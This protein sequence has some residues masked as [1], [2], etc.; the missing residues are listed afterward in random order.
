M[1]INKENLFVKILKF[2]WAKFKS[3]YRSYATEY[4]DDIVKKVIHCRDPHF[5]YVEYRCMCCGD[6]YHRSGF[7]CKT[8]FC[9]HCAR[10]SSNDFIEEIMGKL[11]PGVVYRHLILTIPEQLRI[12]FYNN[13]KSG[14]LY[15]RFINAGKA[16]IDDIFRHV[17]GVDYLKT[18][19]VVALHTAG[20]SGTYNPHL[21][22][23]VMAGGIDP[24]TG[25]WIDLPYFK[26]ENLMPKKGQYHLLTMVK[27]FDSSEEMVALV[28]KLWKKY[29]KGF[30]NNFK[31]GDVPRKITYLV[32]YL[33]KYISKPSISVAAILE[34]DF[35]KD[36][37]IYK[38][39]DHRTRQR[40]VTACDI[41][42]FIGRLAQQIL[43]KGFH[44]IRYF[45][46]QYKEVKTSYNLLLDANF[47]EHHVDFMRPAQANRNVDFHKGLLFNL[48]T[49]YPLLDRS[50][51]RYR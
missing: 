8:K 40:K 49:F 36:K 38:Y 43:P 25:K 35:E 17:T 10:K 5:G 50:I 33:A 24:N 31:K 11:H 4:Y 45:G 23:I 27:C 41:M 18:G 1:S 44:R 14:K 26:Y 34:C 37:V 9:I 2:G 42:T 20:R 15:D 21:H 29:P 39:R 46:I 30:V 12:L 22:I 48:L 6:G 3:T 16:Y 7:S 13:R 28:K 51:S 32:K 47:Q 19:C